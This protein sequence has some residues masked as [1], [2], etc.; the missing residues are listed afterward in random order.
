[1]TR[2]RLI[3]GRVLGTRL[4]RAKDRVSPD[5]RLRDPP[6][7]SRMSLESQRGL[8]MIDSHTRQGGT[9]AAVTSFR[10]RALLFWWAERDEASLGSGGNRGGIGI[11]ADG[12]GAVAHAWFADD[13]VSA[14]AIGHA[15][16]ESALLALASP[17]AG[18]PACRAEAKLRED[19]FALHWHANRA[20]T[21]DIHYLALGGSDLRR[22]AILRLE[23]AHDRPRAAVD[24]G[25]RPELVLFLP[26]A[27]T[28]A[29]AP[30]PGL[31]YGVGA[32][33][34]PHRQGATG[35]AARIGDAAV[36]RSAQRA[37]SVV[38]L[39]SVDGEA[40]FR[41]LARL[42]ELGPSGPVLE[43]TV[44][45]AAS[46]VPVACLAM[47][48]GRFS[49]SLHIGPPRPERDR[50]DHVGFA[51]VG[52]FAFTW[53]LARF[54]EI[55]EVPRLS[56]GAADRAG[57]GCLSWTLR[58]RNEW[59]LEPR[60]RSTEGSLF[61]VLDTRSGNLHACARVAD[62]RAD[63]FTLEWPESDGRRREFV[64]V[65]FGSA[66]TGG[67]RAKL[68]AAIR[69]LF[70]LRIAQAAPRGSSRRPAKQTR[71]QPRCSG[72]TARARS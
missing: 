10:P 12:E 11:H 25:F 60:S 63:G 18:E 49:V 54:A 37:D 34:G 7:R 46:P 35:V 69:R 72:E 41:A 51:P 45:D 55:K 29:D 66:E 22:A 50:V 33:S 62:M 13:R 1:M 61:E 43:V 39:P 57:C 53:G 31:F 38:A 23:L 58:P 67:R 52:L 48:G 15:V 24:V 40:P 19:G 27:A 47:A 70:R 68:V 3:A 4:I 56:V 36:V 17:F 71:A 9:L 14:D 32:A 65:A 42:T 20:G 44:D 30:A 28:G 6:P 8:V 16:G 21:W 59:P 2:I 26:T 5:V 64:Y